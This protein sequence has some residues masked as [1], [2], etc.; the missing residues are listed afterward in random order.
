[1]SGTGPYDPES[2]P[3]RP[4]ADPAGGPYPAGDT[5]PGGIPAYG[6]YSAGPDPYG[7]GPMV[8]AE[9][10][11]NVLNAVKLMYVGAALSA[12]GILIAFVRR[13]AMEDTLE[14]NADTAG[15][16]DAGITPEQL[17]T[18]AVTIAAVVGLI[19]VALW[20]WMA[21][22]NKKGRMWARVVATV[23]GVLNIVFTLYSIVG[24]PMDMFNLVVNIVTVA[25]AAVILYLL[26][27]PDSTAYYQAMSGRR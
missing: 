2:D 5:S 24:S 14:Q 12:L 8:P 16:A 10:P 15:L 23:L 20:L 1:M 3:Y 9:P 19:G 13:G 6:A 25:L 21:A 22:M 17:A 11:Q 26:Y 4:P 27:R 18:T 7:Q